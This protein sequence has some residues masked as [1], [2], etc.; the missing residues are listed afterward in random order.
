MK[1]SC[2]VGGER[3]TIF[4]LKLPKYSSINNYKSHLGPKPLLGMEMEISYGKGGI[5]KNNVEEK[6]ESWRDFNSRS[7]ITQESRW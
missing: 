5:V 2:L 6:Y 1:S 4:L 3:M 7:N